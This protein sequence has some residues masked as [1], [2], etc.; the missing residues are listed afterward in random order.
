MR[1][2]LISQVTL[3]FSAVTFIATQLMVT[4]ALAHHSPAMFDMKQRTTVSGSVKQFQWTN[5]HSYIQLIIKDAD[6]NDVEWSLEMAAPSYLYNN[7]WRPSTL[8]AG[9]KINAIISP[10]ANGAHGGLVIEVTTADGRKLG[11]GSK[12]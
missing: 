12:P 9:D 2:L 5:P 3:L 6:G 10:L 4:T 7:G 1:K 11:G 8:K